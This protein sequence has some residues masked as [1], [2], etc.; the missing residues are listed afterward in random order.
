APSMTNLGWLYETGRGGPQDAGLARSWYE[1]AVAGGNSTAA[2]NLAH[3][4]AR[5][6]PGLARD[7]RTAA[8]HL[9][10]AARAGNPTARGDLDGDMGLWAED[11][12]RALQEMLSASGD[13]RGSIS[14]WWDQPSSDAARAYYMRSQ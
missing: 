3:L 7:P 5:G 4:L 10:V 12:R 2:Y 1:K 11:V 13:Y 6:G 8:R 14:G 9:L